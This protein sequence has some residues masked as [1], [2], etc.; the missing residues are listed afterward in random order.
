MDMNRVKQIISS[1]DDIRVYYH[2]QSVWID[3][4]DEANRTATVHMRGGRTHERHVV[5]V[6]EL[7][8]E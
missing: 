3:E 4:Y 5:S 1:P 8:E 6:E 7:M 2:G